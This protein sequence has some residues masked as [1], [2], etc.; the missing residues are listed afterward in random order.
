VIFMN[1]W[2][3]GKDVKPDNGIDNI[4]KT[5]KDISVICD[6]SFDNIAIGTD[7]DGFT[8]PVDDLYCSNQMQKLTLAML[9]SGIK[10]DDIKKVLGL[11]AM[12]VMSEGWGKI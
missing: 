3:V 2:L 1:Y 10:P 4:V 9:Q 12:R 8:Q 6:G 11:N 5:I 7:M